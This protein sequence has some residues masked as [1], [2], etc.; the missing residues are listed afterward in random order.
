M[1]YLGGI[2]LTTQHSAEPNPL[3]RASLCLLS[4]N[5]GGVRGLSTLYILKG[6]IAR[7]NRKLKPYKLFNL[8]GGT[9]I[10]SLIAIIL[11][12]LKIDVDK[13][14]A[15]YSELIETTGKTK[16]RFNLKKLKSA[17]KKVVTNYNTSNKFVC[18]IAHK[19]KKIVCLRSYSLTNETAL[20][21]LAATSYFNPINIRA[22][23]FTNS[24]LGTNN[25]INKCAEIG[26]L[27]PLVKYF[28]LIGTGNPRKKAI[29]DNILRFLSR[30]LM[31][32]ATQT[33]KT[34]KRFIRY[35]RFNAQKFRVKNCVLNLKQ[36]QSI[37]IENFT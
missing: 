23:R 37:Y 33:E 35:F 29:K 36:K 31:G 9:S 11:G 5:S 12:R 21:I 10:G 22:C 8:I 6:L 2:T 26:D 34:K 3:N 20:V 18:S 24:S 14:I 27:K 28:I 1:S 16:V 30:T 17:I 7:L 32:I 19:T 15:V 4:L 25:P 13:Y